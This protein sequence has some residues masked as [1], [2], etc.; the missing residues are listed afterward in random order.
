MNLRCKQKTKRG[1]KCR[2]LSRRG[3]CGKHPQVNWP[4]TYIGPPG[5]E[6]AADHDP[7]HWIPVDPHFGAGPQSSTVRPR[8]T[9][10]HA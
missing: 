2:N 4:L 3:D 10:P 9:D 7:M 6:D 5:L 8:L 1:Q